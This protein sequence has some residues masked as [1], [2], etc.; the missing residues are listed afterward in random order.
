LYAAIA[1]ANGLTLP[2]LSVSILA[3]LLVI[4]KIF[5]PVLAA[6]ICAWGLAAAAEPGRAPAPEPRCGTPQTVEV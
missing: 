3:Q 5:L 4:T 2:M 6:L 1:V